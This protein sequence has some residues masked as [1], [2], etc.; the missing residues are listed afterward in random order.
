M[1]AYRYI[2]S[3]KVKNEFELNLNDYA[4]TTKKN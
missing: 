4:I 2:P 3:K 1:M